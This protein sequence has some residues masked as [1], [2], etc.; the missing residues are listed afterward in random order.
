LRRPVESLEDITFGDEDINTAEFEGHVFRAKLQ[1]QFNDIFKGNLT[2]SYGDYDK[3]YQNFLSGSLIGE[4][5]T[6]SFGHTLILGGDFIDTQNDNDRFN[7]FFSTSQDD[8]ETFAVAPVI[9]FS[10]NAAGLA[11]TNDFTVNVNDTDEADLTVFSA[12]IQD[13][14][15]ITPYLDVIVGAR[16]DSF[17]FTQAE[18]CRAQTKKF[19]PASASSSNHRKIFQSMAAIAKASF[20]N[21]ANNLPKSAVLK[22]PLRQMCLKTLRRV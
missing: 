13:Q 19:L 11:T 18:H 22:L 10:T 8:V 1:H 6:G 7:T 20:L 14:V 4:F 2:A 5:D 12:Y 21:P 3:L 16:F 9:D 15:A 17:D